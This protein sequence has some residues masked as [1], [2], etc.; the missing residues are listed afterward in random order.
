MKK[1]IFI[2]VAAVLAVACKKDERGQSSDIL[3]YALCRM[4]VNGKPQA[5]AVD[6]VGDSAAVHKLSRYM[7]SYQGRLV[8]CGRG[9][10]ISNH[11]VNA[12]FTDSWTPEFYRRDTINHTFSFTNDVVINWQE[13][14]TI[15]GQF[16]GGVDGTEYL[17]VVVCLE[18]FVFCA[19]YDACAENG[20]EC[21]AGEEKQYYDPVTTTEADSD[22]FFGFH[23]F[24]Y[25][26]L[27]YIPNSQMRANRAYL[28]R[29][30]DEHK[31][32]E[33]LDYFKTSYHI[34]TCTGEEYRELVRLGI[35]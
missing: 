25:D 12:P 9:H 32:Q 19:T 27:G 16:V 24:G 13:K 6:V 5:K 10:F 23:Y 20:V 7:S 11:P 29:L 35:N 18:D 14:N 26:T 22:E 33:M 3:V 17:G 28:Q 21:D 8:N 15:D 30:L 34:Y 31:Y 4:D 2:L 1:I